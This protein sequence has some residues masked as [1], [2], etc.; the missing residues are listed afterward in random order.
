MLFAWDVTILSY[1]W[2]SDEKKNQFIKIYTISTIMLVYS[3]FD[4]IICISNVKWLTL[5]I[6]QFT[7]RLE[8]ISN[9]NNKCWWHFNSKGNF[10][11]IP[12]IFKGSRLLKNFDFTTQLV[13]QLSID[14]AF[15]SIY[16]DNK[17]DVNTESS[18]QSRSFHWRKTC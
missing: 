16:F 6:N 8:H 5:R 7:M 9:V 18:V 15:H 2:I 4:D 11:T 3:H 14:I 10:N 17:I 13:H 1:W 12:Y